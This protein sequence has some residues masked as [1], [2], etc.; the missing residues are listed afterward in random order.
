MKLFNV[1]AFA[2]GARLLPFLFLTLLLAGCVNKDITKANYD[3]IKV[4]K[5][6]KQVEAIIGPP[7]VGV[8]GSGC[9]GCTIA[10][11]YR[12]DADGHIVMDTGQIEWMENHQTITLK[13]KYGRVT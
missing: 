13:F 7:D 10:G 6:L 3:K 12:R 2:R 9:R 4:G 1:F 11:S 5:T 8:Q